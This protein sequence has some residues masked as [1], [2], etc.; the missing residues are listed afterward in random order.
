ME[1][2]GMDSSLVLL[3]FFRRS[4]SVLCQPSCGIQSSKSSRLVIYLIVLITNMSSLMDVY[5]DLVIDYHILLP[6]PV[7]ALTVIA[8]VN[9]ISFS[10]RHLYCIPKMCRTSGMVKVT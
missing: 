7:N 9:S 5:A 8:A 6:L 4:I 1:T 10:F 2:L 3:I